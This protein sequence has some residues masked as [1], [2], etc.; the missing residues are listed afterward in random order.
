MDLYLAFTSVTT[1]L[2]LQMLFKYVDGVEL[3]GLIAHLVQ[4]Q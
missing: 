1:S 4:N 3:Q 2:L